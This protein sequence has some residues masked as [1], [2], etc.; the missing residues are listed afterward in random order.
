MDIFYGNSGSKRLRWKLLHVL[1]CEHRPLLIK[2][3]LSQP[4][5]KGSKNRLQLSLKKKIKKCMA[6]FYT[7]QD[8]IHIRCLIPTYGIFH[9]LH[10]TSI[11]AFESIQHWA[12]KNSHSNLV[13]PYSLFCVH[14]CMRA[15]RW[16]WPFSLFLSLHVICVRVNLSS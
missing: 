16:P 7:P 1:E 8:M 11:C 3:V 2:A 15:G 12:D 9:V 6:F 4:R 13:T 14:M 10:F 5:F